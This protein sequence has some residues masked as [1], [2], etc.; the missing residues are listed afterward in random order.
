M[1][2]LKEDT[3]LIDCKCSGKSWLEIEVLGEYKNVIIKKVKTTVPLLGIF[4][5]SSI[6]SSKINCNILDLQHNGMLYMAMMMI[7]ETD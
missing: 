5:L 4:L 7:T 3:L 2:L 1:A 6:F